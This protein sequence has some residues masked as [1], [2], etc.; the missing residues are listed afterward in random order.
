MYFPT[1]EQVEEYARNANLVPV[2]REIS[3]DLETPVS[4]YLKV[5]RPPYSYLLESVEGGESA[6]QALQ[7]HRHRSGGDPEDRRRRNP[8]RC[9]SAR[10]RRA[11]AV[12]VQAGRHRLSRQVQWRRGWLHR[13]RRR[14]ALRE[15]CLRPR[16]TRS[17]CRSRCSCFRQPTWFSITS[18]TG[19]RSSATRISR[20]MRGGRMRK[21]AP[22]STT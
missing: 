11:D 15:G 10:P 18:G 13:L 4:A 1:L 14:P 7:L 16:K 2:Y 9:R 5:A 21:P 3:A 8:R 12:K 20:E 17:D 19:S 6:S 22:V